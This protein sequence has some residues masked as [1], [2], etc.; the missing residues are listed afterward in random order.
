MTI[1]KF[2]FLSSKPIPLA[3]NLSPCLS[4]Y[5]IRLLSIFQEH[6]STT[7]SLAL[8]FSFSITLSHHFSWFPE[9]TIGISDC[10]TST[11]CRRRSLTVHRS[12][13]GYFPTGHC[14]RPLAAAV[15][16]PRKHFVTKRRAGSSKTTFATASKSQNR[17]CGNAI[18][19]HA[20]PGKTQTKPRWNSEKSN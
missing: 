12:T 20:R 6:T 2:S 4:I 8:F 17:F 11:Q 1:P 7:I 13:R 16:K 5:L 10:G 19:I 15:R 9:D 18:W 3:I 14:A